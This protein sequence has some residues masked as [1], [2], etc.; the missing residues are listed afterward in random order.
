[1]QK[2]KEEGKVARSEEEYEEAE[3]IRT[4]LLF[5]ITHTLYTTP[6]R[7]TTDSPML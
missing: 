5:I 1:M 7:P 3:K 6:T 4:K 2:R